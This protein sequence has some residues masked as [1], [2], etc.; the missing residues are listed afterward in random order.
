VKETIPTLRRTLLGVDDI[1]QNGVK[2]THE[3][4]YHHKG[5]IGGV[6]RNGVKELQPLPAQDGNMDWGNY[7]HDKEDRTKPFN[8]YLNDTITYG[9]KIIKND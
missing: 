7:Y 4:T 8:S 2:E 1:V 3:D 5:R 9:K 6:I